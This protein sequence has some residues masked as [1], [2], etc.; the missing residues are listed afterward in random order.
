[1][2]TFDHLNTF[3][4]ASFSTTSCSHPFVGRKVRLSYTNPDRVL[5]DHLQ[6]VQD[7]QIPSDT[8]NERRFW[9]DRRSRARP[10]RP[11]SESPSPRLEL[12]LAPSDASSSLTHAHPLVETSGF[13]KT[14]KAQPSVLY[15]H[16]KAFGSDLLDVA[17]IV[18]VGVFI[19]LTLQFCG[20]L[21][22]HPGVLVP[23]WIQPGISTYKDF[24]TWMY[25]DPHNV[26]GL[27]PPISVSTIHSL[28]STTRD[29]I[30]TTSSAQTN[31]YSTAWTPLKRPLR[32][33][34]SVE[35]L[36]SRSTRTTAIH[37]A[38]TILCQCENFE[39]RTRR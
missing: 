28:S 17:K 32:R 29:A 11:R 9:Q 3:P 12:S 2:F 18:F 4:R 36:A 37:T 24:P 33:C 7:E 10:I 13:S 20:R 35:R 38:R 23:S 34:K 8:L 26:L 22:T 6:R 25:T 21:T 31:G 14:A 19:A 5:L 16:I 30:S 15:H 27:A 1:M 39:L